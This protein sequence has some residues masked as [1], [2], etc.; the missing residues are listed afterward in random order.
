[1]LLFKIWLLSLKK[2]KFI[3]LLTL[4]ILSVFSMPQ[5]IL[6]N[7]NSEDN[8]LTGLITAIELILSIVFLIIDIV[9]FIVT[10]FGVIGGILFLVKYFNVFG[11]KVWNITVK[12]SL[13]VISDSNNL[14]DS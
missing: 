7:P 9:I 1:M 11:K 3:L 2:M 13:N 14:Y 6:D 12:E 4:F 5:N 10:L 8:F